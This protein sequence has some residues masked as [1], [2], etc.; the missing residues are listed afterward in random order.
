MCMFSISTYTLSLYFVLSIPHL[1][2]W[3]FRTYYSNLVFRRIFSDEFYVIS[4]LKTP[5]YLLIFRR[6]N[7]EKNNRKNI[8][9]NIEKT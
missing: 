5:N 6:K 3:A 4:G 1:K 9:E 8:I 7:R 2:E